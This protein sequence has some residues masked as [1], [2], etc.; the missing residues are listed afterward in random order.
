MCQC[1][2]EE[3]AKTADLLAHAIERLEAQ[4]AMNNAATQRII[5]DQLRAQRESQRAAAAQWDAWESA[6]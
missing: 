1:D 3:A 6:L 2:E 5:Q 4:E